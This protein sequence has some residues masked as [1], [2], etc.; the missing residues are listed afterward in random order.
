M[1]FEYRKL[2]GRIVEKYGTNG[3]FAE[4]INVSLVTVSNKLRGVTQFSQDDI[5][6]WCEALEIPLAE[7]GSYFFA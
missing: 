6:L 2:R 1:S 7:S 4:K 5:I 3:N